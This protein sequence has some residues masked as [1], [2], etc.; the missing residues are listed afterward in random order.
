METNSNSGATPDKHATDGEAVR[1]D[2]D[3]VAQSERSEARSSMGEA[4]N[5]VGSDFSTPKAQ[6]VS[7]EDDQGHAIHLIYFDY[8]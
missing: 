4:K 8:Q 3:Q 5:S 1:F 2:I 7:P 6:P